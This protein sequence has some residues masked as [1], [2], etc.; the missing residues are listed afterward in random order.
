[1]KKIESREANGVASNEKMELEEGGR[2]WREQGKW[3]KCSEE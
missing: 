3:Q 2:K 1:M